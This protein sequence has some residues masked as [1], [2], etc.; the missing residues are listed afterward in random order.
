MKYLLLLLALPMYAQFGAAS[1]VVNGNG[2]PNAAQCVSSGNVGRVYARKDGGATY[3]TFYVCSNTAAS[4]YEWELM[5]AGGGGGSGTVTSVVASGGVQTSSGSAI[6]TTGTVRGALTANAQTGTTYTFLTGD[7]GKVVTLSNAAA[8]A[9]TLPQAGSGF[10]DGWFVIAKNIGAGDVTITP[11]TSTISGAAAITVSTGEWA[12]ITSNGTNYEAQTVHLTV[13]SAL[14]ITRSRTSQQI[15]V[16]ATVVTLAGVQTLTDKTLTA[17]IMT[18][19]VL[20]T[21]A[22]GDGTTLTGVTHTIASGT[23]ALDTDAIASTACDTLATTT[24]TGAASTDVVIFTANAD[25]TAVTGYAPV[26]TGGLAIYAWP[27]TNT[28]NWKVCNPTSSSITP[29]AVTLNY[30]IVR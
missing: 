30:R 21:I 10:E 26:T 19:P 22:S 2:A 8:I 3:S 6:T 11:T 18:A 14:A 24:A 28:I 16:G 27:T 9:V 25:I 1:Q 12:L 5:G 20:G 4:T 29:G 23:K 15:G 7:R 17:P 13:D